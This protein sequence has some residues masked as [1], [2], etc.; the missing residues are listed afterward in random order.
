MRLAQNEDAVRVHKVGSF[1]R[2]KG[3]GDEGQSPCDAHFGPERHPGR[4]SSAR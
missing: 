1:V 3:Q 2:V 4:Q